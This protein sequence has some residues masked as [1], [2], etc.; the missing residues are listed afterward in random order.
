MAVIRVKGLKRYRVKGRWYAYHRKSGVRLV[1]EF[2]TAEFI[3]ELESLERKL[4]KAEAL[5]GTMGKLFASYR[6]SPAFTDLAITSR[7]GYSRMMNLLKP[8]DEM[9]L[10]ELTPHFIA[11]LRDKMA[12]RHG[13]R[14]ANY[15]MAVISV[16]CEHGKN[17]GSFA[18]IQSRA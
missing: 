8:L 3:A 7:N 16:A 9:P 18:K 12:E 11:G 17:R 13:R 10:V 1:S 6:T 2:G 14:Q 15:V 4:Q 5:P